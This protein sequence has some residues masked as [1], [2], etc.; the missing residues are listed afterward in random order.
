MSH[1]P[2]T[3]GVDERPQD[4]AGR[5]A[6]A[7]LLRLSRWLRATG[8]LVLLAAVASAGSFWCRW[9]E[10]R[11]ADPHGAVLRG[12]GAIS[13]LLVRTLGLEV[14]RE[15][16]PPAERCLIV[17]NHRS[18]V[19]IPLVL[20]HVDAVFL[21]KVE[22][23][24][25]PVFGALARRAR[26][27][28][29]RREDA[30]SRIQALARLGEMLDQAR[31]LVVFP[32]GSTSR[33]P[34][35]RRFRAGSFRLAAGRGVKVVPVAIAYGDPYDAW[36]DDDDFVTHFLARFA[37][38]RMRVTIA[39]GPPL[40]GRDGIELCTRAQR[41]IEERLAALDRHAPATSLIDE[42]SSALDRR[43]G[44]IPLET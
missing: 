4:R 15:G 28:F 12:L 2:A 22:I 32:E 3:V 11:A 41:W 39:F 1:W 30:D 25:W 24:E 17:A 37:L 29:V 42:G 34:G 21:S 14:E 8:R 19:D 6:P 23:G 9:R 26:T 33:G 13:R 36:V 18:Y 44:L 7:A 31:S 38:P 40:E 27:V 5:G 35:L 10:A 16:E 20:A 43:R